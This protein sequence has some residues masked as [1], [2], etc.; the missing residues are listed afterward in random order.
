[1]CK[2]LLKIQ[3]ETQQSLKEILDS[4]SQRGALQKKQ[5]EPAGSTE[6]ENGSKSVKRRLHDVRHPFGMVTLNKF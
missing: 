4:D 6:V 3:S 5:N 1:M 2:K